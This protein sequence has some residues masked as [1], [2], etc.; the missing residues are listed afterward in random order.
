[1]HYWLAPGLNSAGFADPNPLC[2]LPSSARDHVPQEA[3]DP[4]L[5]LG[6]I[7]QGLSREKVIAF[8]LL[9]A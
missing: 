5:E 9:P 3:F 1:M 4:G 7:K 8:V 2:L 6:V